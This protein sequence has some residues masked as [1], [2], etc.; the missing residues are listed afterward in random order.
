M[1]SQSPFQ[2]VRYS[3]GAEE[4]NPRQ[5]LE[6]LANSEVADYLSECSMERNILFVTGCARSGT[7]LLQRCLST[8]QS[9]VFYWSENTLYQIY[10][11]KL[12]DGKNLILKRTGICHQFFDRVPSFVKI[13]HIVRHP[14][15]VLTSRVRKKDGY[16]VS[17]K[18]WKNEKK[19]FE[20]FRQVHP[21]ENLLV[22]RYEDL[23]SNPDGVQKLISEKFFVNFDLLFSDYCERNFLD[24]KIDIFTKQP[25]VWFPIDSSISRQHRSIHEK[26][27]LLQS[28]RD[29]QRRMISDFCRDFGYELDC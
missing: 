25:R 18:R 3:Q 7:S 12:I 26:M 1:N 24:G 19:A 23:V 29:E 16:Y 10:N 9:P 11:Q 8:I 5:Q 15:D 28:F 13:L 6:M 4:L 20:A 14:M 22:I 2:V 17:F 21:A 27:S